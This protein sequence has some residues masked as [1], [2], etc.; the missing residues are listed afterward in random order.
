MRFKLGQ[1]E[2]ESE[3]G[4]EL[5]GLLKKVFGEKAVI[6]LATEEKPEPPKRVIVRRKKKEEQPKPEEKPAGA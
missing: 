5:I 6:V 1:L 2:I 4:N 3:D